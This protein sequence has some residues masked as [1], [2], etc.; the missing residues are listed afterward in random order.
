ML[1]RVF[2]AQLRRPCEGD[3]PQIVQKDLDD[4]EIRLSFNE[5]RHTKK[6][7]F[8]KLVVEACKRYSFKKLIKLKEGKSKGKRLSIIN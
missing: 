6:H 4:F 7:T 2:R 5:I 8:K 1:P 3:W